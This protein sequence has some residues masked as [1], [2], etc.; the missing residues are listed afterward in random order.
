MNAIDSGPGLASGSVPAYALAAAPQY[1]LT[2]I[3]LDGGGML[4][5][6]FTADDYNHDGVVTL[7]HGE[8]LG[9]GLS[10]E[11]DSFLGSLA[12]GM[13]DLQGLVWKIGTPWLGDEAVARSIEG[14]ASDGPVGGFDC[15]SGLGPT[16]SIGGRVIDSKGGHLSMTAQ[17]IA[18]AAVPEPASVVL[19]LAGIGVMS[20]L[21]RLRPGN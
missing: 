7:F 14:I 8:V 10:F 11:G 21:A 5:G 12:L 18:V 1:R 15:A 19:P 2:Q 20:L 3:G 16:G 4:Q 17:A 9:F 13:D 6:R